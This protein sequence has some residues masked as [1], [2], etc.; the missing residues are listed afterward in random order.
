MFLLFLLTLS[1][2]ASGA[3]QLPLVDFLSLNWKEKALGALKSLG[4]F[5]LLSHPLGN[6][7]F[8]PW[9]EALEAS[10]ELFASPLEEKNAIAAEPP[11]S[12]PVVRGY[13]KVG[14]ESGTARRFECKERR[15]N[16]IKIRLRP[17]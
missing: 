11:S 7:S 17:D 15:V 4:A 5:Q 12:E 1:H 13:F 9:K 14:G 10:Q 6:S 16:L 2:G 8:G 3:V